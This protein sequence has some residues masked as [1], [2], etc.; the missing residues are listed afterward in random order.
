MCEK[1]ATPELGNGHDPTAAR[2]YGLALLAGVALVV[3]GDTS[4]VEAAGFVSPFLVMF[5]QRR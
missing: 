3:F 4:S 5:E 2:I 1:P